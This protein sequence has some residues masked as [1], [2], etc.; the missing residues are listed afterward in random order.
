MKK[1]FKR[2]LACFSFL[3]RL[4][5]W[6]LTDISE[7]DMK[8]TSKYFPL[9]GCF[10]GAISACIIYFVDLVL[11]I[12]IAILLSM[13]GSIILTGAFHEDGLA[14]VCDGFGAGYSKDKILD[15]MKDSTTGVFGSV[16]LMMMLALK[17][18]ALLSVP[19]NII[20]P[21]VIIGHSISRWTSISFLYSHNYARK[22][23]SSKSRVYIKRPPFYEFLIVTLL[24]IA[25]FFLLSKEL[26]VP[27]LLLII[28]LF[29]IK[30][31]MGF[32]F[33]IK[34]GGYTGDCMGATQQ[35]A[36]LFF[37]LGIIIIITNHIV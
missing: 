30:T 13:A 37:Y 24:G 8:Q 3:T 15:I 20:V 35:I 26:L 21:I 17:F 33:K 6:K 12:E 36:E 11:P 18:F 22:E 1:E 25:P 4:P 31:L 19:T 34:I 32:Y 16:G 5:V 2:L 29:L 14:D 23:G 7:V 10:V 9:V 28:P 27:S